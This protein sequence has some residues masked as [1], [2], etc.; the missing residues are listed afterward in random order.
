MPEARYWRVRMK[1]GNDRLAAGLGQRTI[2]TDQ[3]LHQ[4][5]KG[6]MNIDQ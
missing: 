4:R 1:D 5:C 2:Q 6:S 3:L